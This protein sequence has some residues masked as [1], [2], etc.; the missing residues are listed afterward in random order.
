M[1]DLNLV[2]DTPQ[3]KLLIMLLERVSTLEDHVLTINNQLTELLSLTTSNA[4]SV[5]VNAKNTE[6]GGYDD[7]LTTSHK[8]KDIIETIIPCV[9]IY[10]NF[11][12]PGA[13]GGMIV[14]HTKH[15]QVISTING[16]LNPALSQLMNVQTWQML[17]PYHMLKSL[18]WM[19]RFKPL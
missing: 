11:T 9:N 3:D 4:F 1:T 16:K 12:T 6:T 13:Y 10:T 17:S 7:L 8:M 14:I 15:P 2:Y 18:G 5:H 19:D